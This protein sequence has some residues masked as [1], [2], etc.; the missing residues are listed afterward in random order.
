M[1]VVKTQRGG[2]SSSPAP[3][4]RA[5]TTR[6]VGDEPGWTSGSNKWQ[7]LLLKGA[8]SRDAGA[9][10]AAKGCS[11]CASPCVGGFFQKREMTVF[12]L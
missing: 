7:L 3:E 6:D 9:P 10:F 1:G 4:Q 12:R 5:C 8:V 11:R 2:F